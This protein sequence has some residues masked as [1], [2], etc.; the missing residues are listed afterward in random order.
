MFQETRDKVVKYFKENADGRAPIFWL[1]LFTF[2]ESSCFP[3]PP[4]TLQVILT[5]AKPKRWLYFVMNIVVSSLLGGLFGY[6]IGYA[7]F[8]L[9][10][11]WLIN[12]YN[13]HDEVVKVG[14]LFQNNVFWP[15]FISAFTPVPYKVFTIAAG[16]FKVNLIIF[17]IASLL[18]RGLRFFLIGY[19][20]RYFGQKYV[21]KIL[22]YFNL[23]LLAI[24]LLLVIYLLFKFI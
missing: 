15:V 1:D 20:V 13:L 10:G 17:T 16:L 7:L 11:E 9:F 23:I 18:G 4:D 8:D 24:V 3:I 2:L 12:L 22:K 6:F 5:L 14:E 21:E 19:I